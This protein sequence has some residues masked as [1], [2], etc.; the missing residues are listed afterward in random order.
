MERIYYEKNI[1]KD[2]IRNITDRFLDE[3]FYH[4]SNL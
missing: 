2:V 3:K 4:E 1:T